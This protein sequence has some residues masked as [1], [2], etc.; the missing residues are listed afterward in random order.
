MEY[1]TLRKYKKLTRLYIILC[2]PLI[3]CYICAMYMNATNS[4]MIKEEIIVFGAAF[5]LGIVICLVIMIYPI[6]R[7][8][9]LSKV[10]NYYPQQDGYVE[11]YSSYKGSAS[12]AVSVKGEIFYTKRLFPRGEAKDLVGRTVTCAYIE[13]ELFIYN[14]KG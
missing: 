5:T 11:S 4:W 8:K 7:Y 3:L 13:N 1:I 12:L 2:I 6:Y 9:Y 10:C 14:I